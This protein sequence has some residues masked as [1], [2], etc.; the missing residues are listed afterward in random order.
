MFSDRDIEVLGH[1]R[2]AGVG[3]TVRAYNVQELSAPI[4]KLNTMLSAVATGIYRLDRLPGLRGLGMET[5]TCDE[6]AED[7]GLCQDMPVGG[8]AKP[9]NENMQEI[10]ESSPSLSAISRPTVIPIC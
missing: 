3:R 2:S 1:H 6:A 7:G 9:P 8:D 10:L 4:A 5:D